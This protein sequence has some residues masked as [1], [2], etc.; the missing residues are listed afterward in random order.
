MKVAIAAPLPL[1]MAFGGLEV[2]TLRTADAL[3]AQGIEVEFLDPWKRTFDADLLHCF[4]SEYQLHELVMYAAARGIPVVV[5]AVFLARRSAYWYPPWR[6]I[7]PLIPLQTSFRL[8]GQILRT[9]RAVVALTESEALDLRRYFGVRRNTVHVIGNGVDD[10]FRAATSDEFRE[11]HGLDDFALSVGTLA[12]R[13]NQL[14]LVQALAGTDLTLVLI[15]APDM[16]APEYAKEVRKAAR[17]APNV[18]LLPAIPHESSLLVS[19]FAAAQCFVLASLAEAQPLSALEATAA[20]TGM[21]LSNLPTLRA[22]FGKQARYF[23]PQ[24]SKAIREA[25]TRVSA[26]APGVHRDAGAAIPS[27]SEVARRLRKIYDTVV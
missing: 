19:A 14:R 24:S 8:R 1:A 21:A 25:V 3:R 4:G 6:W 27:W 26:E 9:A 23:N 16:R 20:G 2:Q 7:D 12:P 17:S 5:T 15:G 13:K 10:R 18:H 11:H 22:T